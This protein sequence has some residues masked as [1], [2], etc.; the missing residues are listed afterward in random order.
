MDI[1]S[2]Q[3]RRPYL[4][5]TAHWIAKVGEMAALQTKAALIAFHRVCGSHDGTHP[6]K[7]VIDLLD[8]AG[9]TVKVKIV[10]G[11][12]NVTLKSFRSV[13]LLWTMRPTMTQQCGSLNADSM[14]VTSPLM[15][16]IAG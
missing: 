11:V 16:L 3:N 4:A 7:I 14:L 8:R 13:I 5:M 9:I 10:L 6:V 1:W 2:D 12:Y 15:R